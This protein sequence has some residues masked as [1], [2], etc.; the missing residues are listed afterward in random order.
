MTTIT[1]LQ[2]ILNSNTKTTAPPSAADDAQDRFLKLLVTQ[3]QNQ[4]PLNPMDNAEVTTQ[5]A[6]L[7]TVTGIE[8][9]NQTLATMAASSAAQQSLQAAMLVGREVLVTGNTLNFTGQAVRFGIDVPQAVDGMTITIADSKGNVVESFQA[10]AQPQ[11]STTF[12]WDGLDADGKALASGTYT[13]SAKANAGSAAVTATPLSSAIVQS[14]GTAADGSVQLQLSGQ[15]TV[16][17]A[18]IKRFL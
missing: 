12:S 4:D 1:D 13:V 17:I 8:K 16:G 5:L 11:G 9:L 7:N 10:G 3:M 15:G 14:V 6:Q 2:S 18:D